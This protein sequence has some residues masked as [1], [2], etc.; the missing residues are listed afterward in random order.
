M[1][2]KWILQAELFNEIHRW[3]A[4]D[5]KRIERT[6]T[7]KKHAEKFYDVVR[8]FLKAAEKVWGDAWGNPDYFVTSS[9][10]LKA[11]I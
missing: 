8:D 6:G 3:V 4:A 9:V 11:M 1:Q 2:Q 7:E 10:T 5:W